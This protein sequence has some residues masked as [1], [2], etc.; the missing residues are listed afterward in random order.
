MTRNDAALIVARNAWPSLAHYTLDQWQKY[1]PDFLGRAHAVVNALC[2]DMPALFFA[3]DIA[4]EEAAER[5]LEDAMRDPGHN[6]TVLG[7]A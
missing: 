4:A 5:V 6:I 2:P 3:P 7:A 1:A